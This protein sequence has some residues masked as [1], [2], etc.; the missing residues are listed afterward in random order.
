MNIQVERKVSNK[1]A[2]LLFEQQRL[3]GQTPSHETLEKANTPAKSEGNGATH[4]AGTENLVHDAERN[5]ES[6]IHSVKR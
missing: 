3:H 4:V 1:N 2:R 5:S 6:R